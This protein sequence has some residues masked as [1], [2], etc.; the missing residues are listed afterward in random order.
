M[1]VNAPDDPLDTTENCGNVRCGGFGDFIDI[2]IDLEGRPWAALSHNPDGDTGIVGT[3][4][5]GP[6]L[7]GD[8][9]NL[10]TLPVGGSSTL[11]QTL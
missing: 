4:I 10:T 8:L 7:R 11:G 5:A 9:Q 1:A 2:A 3:F 6:A